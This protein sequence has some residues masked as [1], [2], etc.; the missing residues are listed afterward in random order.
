[1]TVHVYPNNDWIEHDVEY[2]PNERECLCKPT[3]M[4]IDEDTGL[5][6]NEPIIVHNMV[7]TED[8]K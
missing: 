7:S 8:G 1:M 3:I 5:P 2:S 6:L 4:Y